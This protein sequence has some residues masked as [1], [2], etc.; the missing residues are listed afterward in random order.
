[1]QSNAASMIVSNSA[2]VLRCSIQELLLFK[3]DLFL[4]IIYKQ[5]HLK[6]NKINLGTA[7]SLLTMQFYFDNFLG[8]IVSTF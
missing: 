2:M 4:V 8:G 3:T 1:M 7:K 6:N 5:I